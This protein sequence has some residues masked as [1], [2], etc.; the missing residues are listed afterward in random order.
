MAAL[1]CSSSVPP[2]P[3]E[4]RP[5]IVVL[6]ADDLGYGDLASFGHPT[7]RTPNLDQLAAE[8]MRLTS[9]YSA[10]WCVPA[11]LQLMTGR[12]SG[13]VDVG[14]TGVDGDGSIPESETT[15]AQA[16]S[17]VGYRTGM[18][19]KWHLGYAQEEYL[20]VGKGFDSWFGLPYSNDMRRPWVDTDEPLWL[21]DNTTKFEHP[22][23]QD[24][25]TTRY[26]ER[27]VNFIEQGDGQ[28]FFLYA[29]Y[30]MPHLPVHTTEEFQGRSRAGLYGDV[31]ETID[32]S[33]GQIVAAIEETGQADNTIIVFTSDN[34]PWL[35]LPSR[36][37]QDEVEPWHTGS[38]GPLRGAKATTYEGGVRVPFIVRWP[39]RIEPGRVS[40][41][42]VSTV[43]LLPTFLAASG[44]DLPHQPLDGLDLT[45]FLSGA[46]EQS[47]RD[48]FYYFYNRRLEGVRSGPWKLR[49][50]DGIEL[51]NLELDP[52]ERYNRAEDRPEVVKE[53]SDLMAVMRSEVEP[54]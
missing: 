5:N 24:T 28:P 29:A 22:V 1:S 30:S 42:I 41:D 12:Y 38:P 47:P 34:G 2:V 4:T 20:P 37:L 25:L 54:N 44:T 53:L 13:R 23:D 10:P 52:S 43:D 6:F 7:I 26:T 48:D 8:G 18:V 3:D 35:N 49:T 40:A 21:Y 31:I 50:L 39:A 14:R 27:A 16:L 19:G 15:M 51:F 46:S 17:A 45:P 36:M 33:V 11:R 9:F 32:W